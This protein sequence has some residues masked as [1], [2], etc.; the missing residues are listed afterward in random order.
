MKR[1]LILALSVAAVAAQA[2][3][4]A[5]FPSAGSTVIASVGDLGTSYGYFWSAG[6][7]DMV[8]ETWGSTGILAT[9]GLDLNLFVTE[10]VLSSGN[11]V[12]WDGRVNGTSVGSFSVGSG[13]LGA[14]N[15]SYNFA[16]IVGA[17]TY[18][19]G[20]HVTNEVTPGGGSI[21]LDH[22]ESTMTLVDAVPEPASMIALGAGALALVRRR[23]K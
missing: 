18:T 13:F 6:R 7:G 16:P 8:E 21:A 14:L 12:D 15:Q 17:G 3:F 2:D 11:T 22:T 5:P 19:V 4:T 9:V 10:N 20:I 23:R 1:V